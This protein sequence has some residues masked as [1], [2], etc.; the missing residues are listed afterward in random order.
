MTNEE[1]PQDKAELVTLIADEW[2]ALLQIRDKL[3]PKQMTTADGGGWSP[4]DTLAHLAAWERFMLRRYLQ[5]QTP[6]Q[7]MQIEEAILEQ[8]E[9]NDINQILFERNRLRD[10]DDV[11]QELQQ[12]HAELLDR[13]EQMTFADLMQ[14]NAEDP[15][16]RPMIIWVMGNTY[17]HYREHRET[18]EATVQE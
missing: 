9:E 14:P 2:T 17:Q 1:I 12:T 3:T 4:K 18:I 16:H 8:L 7:A 5:G 11:L 15:Q 6:H 10:V 13:L